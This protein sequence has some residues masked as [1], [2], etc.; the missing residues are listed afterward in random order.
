[1]LGES[2]LTL[3]KRVG[4]LRKFGESVFTSVCRRLTEDRKV[5]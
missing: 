2:V 5:C 3:P 1:M 4:G